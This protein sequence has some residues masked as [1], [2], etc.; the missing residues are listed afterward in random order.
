MS[1]SDCVSGYR[2]DIVSAVTDLRT[3]R[4]VVV[5]RAETQLMVNIRVKQPNSAEPLCYAGD[6]KLGVQLKSVSV[7]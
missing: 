7:V 3:R 6:T 2:S 5:V 4:L 1:G